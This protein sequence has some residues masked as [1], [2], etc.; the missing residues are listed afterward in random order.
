MP[1][2]RHAKRLPFVGADVT[3][4]TLGPRG[5]P[6]VCGGACRVVP[7]VD[8]RAA[9]QEGVGLGTA[10]VVLDRARKLLRS[11]YWPYPDDRNGIVTLVRSVHHVRGGIG[12]DACWEGPPGEGSV[13]LAG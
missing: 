5:A 11:R 13:N 10:A 3:R 8:V 12:G 4:N 9:G 6:L 2:H 1:R 7:G